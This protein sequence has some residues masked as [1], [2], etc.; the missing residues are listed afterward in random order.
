M[1]V[2]LHTQSLC[3]AFGGV[4][5]VDEVDLAIEE[6][7]IRALIGPNGSGKT[8]LLN[9]V[10]GFYRA[11]AGSVTL[12]NHTLTGKRPSSIVG[13]GI[14]R[15]YQHSRLFHTLT[16]VENVMVGNHCRM[17]AGMLGALVRSPAIRR[18]EKATREKALRVLDMV[19]LGEHHDVL[20]G[21]LPFGVQR[22]VELARALATDPRLLLLDE[23]AAGMSVQEKEFLMQTLARTRER[24]ITILLVEHDM[25]VVM[26]IAD[27]VSVLNFGKKIAE[28]TPDEVQQNEAVLDA[29][30]G[31][32]RE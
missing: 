13:L 18:E 11:T 22:L 4:R 26:N 31:R 23:P 15:T 8:T 24:G 21:S 28:G 32:D 2:I 7:E 6:G 25:S 9:L 30:L 3:K 16:T 29:Y 20:P 17:R 27:I 14:A 19:G 12:L 1:S 10:S 5:A